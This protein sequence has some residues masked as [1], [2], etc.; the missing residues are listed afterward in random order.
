MKPLKLEFKGI[1]SFSEHAIIDFEA[2]TKTGIFGIFGDTGSGKSTIL[3]CINF[4][5]YGNVK[6]SEIKTDIINYRCAS[7]EVKFV[8]NILNNGKRKTYTVERV[9]KKDKSGTHK[10]MLFEN[11]GEREVCIAD[12]ASAVE[13]K[14]IEILGVGDED[15]RKCIA[16]PQGEF[17]Q[18]VK[19]TPSVRLAL[20]E[21]LFSLSKYGDRLKEKLS[22]RQ[23]AVESE[24]QNL[25]GQ[26]KGYENVSKETLSALK[27]RTDEQT[28]RLA[29]LNLS[30]K[31]AF[32]KYEKLNALNEKRAE[33]EKTLKLI[34]QLTA[35][36]S[37]VEELRKSLALLPA[38]REAVKL[39]EEIT[40]KLAEADAIN[41]EISKLSA[42]LAGETEL[43]NRL[44]AESKKSDFDMRIADCTALSAAYKSAEGKPEKLKAVL[45][46][47]EAKRAEYKLKEERFN[48]ITADLRLAETATE[49]A[50]KN[51]A[52]CA[53]ANLN[54][55]FEGQFKGAVLKEEYAKNLDYFLRLGGDIRELEENSP[56]FEFID[57]EVKTKI[58]EYRQR[59]ADV[60]EFS[61]SA[62]KDKLRQLQESDEEREKLQKILT[63]KRGDLQKLV[64]LLQLCESELKTIKKDGA[65]LRLRADE[66][67]DEL[68]KIFGENCADYALAVSRNEAALT[69]LKQQKT[70][71][72]ARLEEVKNGKN[73]LEISAEKNKAL[74]VAAITEAENLKKKL[75]ALLEENKFDS[76]EKCVKTVEEF[77]ALANAEQQLKEYDGKLAA[78]TEKRTELEKIKGI[79]EAS[80]DAV[81]LAKAEKRT[82][83]EEISKL[84]GETAVLNANYTDCGKRLEEK[85]LLL[86]DF[87]KI[88]RERDL[89]SQLKDLTKN[90]KFL[91]FIANEYLCDI[92]ALASSTLL[93]LTDGRY[94]LTYKDNAFFVGDNFDCGNLRGVNTLSGGETFLVSLSLALALSQTI[95]AKSM[96]TIEFFFLDEGFGTLDSALVDTVMNALEKLKSS[97]FT[98]GVISHVEE[99]KHRID[100]KI[101]VIKA[102]ESHGSTVQISC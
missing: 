88:N 96:K 95:C 43:L 97:D 8:F 42:K 54:A 55:I 65:E 44:E 56:L 57:K 78:L 22:L 13:K 60:S 4:A 72:A 3:D 19:S 5:L 40:A 47:L 41:S 76:V 94:F 70:E 80:D 28:K 75:R 51:L 25:D 26:L 35:E 14:I 52:E 101:T 79:C 49:Q 7:A 59:V 61:L 6:R 2:L 82:L 53:G 37:R 46:Q 11:D 71:L 24:F 93:K 64:S 74:H 87:E 39:N 91:E 17:A 12:K 102:T 89:L 18:F 33:L 38:C 20:I 21:R 77:T 45:K 34:E 10:A 15:F 86:K 30:A 84:T 92:S 48:K 62:V 29:K 9:L 31:T 23:R 73:S 69:K 16:L 98:I 85:N 100:S 68:K 50:E 1:N 90:N 58:A 66:I 81:S 99:L 27:T 83:E 32:D 36:H 67:E 63:E